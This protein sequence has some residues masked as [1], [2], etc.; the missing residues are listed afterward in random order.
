MPVL[1][2]WARE[3]VR[4]D[5]YQVEMVLSNNGVRLLVSAARNAVRYQVYSRVQDMYVFVTF[6]NPR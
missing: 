6:A 3:A 5:L 4:N 2:V 1:F